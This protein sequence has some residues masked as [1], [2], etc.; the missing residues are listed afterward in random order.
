MLGVGA[1]PPENLSALILEHVH[2]A[3]V[4]LGLRILACGKNKLFGRRTF[5]WT[6]SYVPVASGKQDTSRLF[7]TCKQTDEP[8]RLSRFGRAC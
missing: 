2:K 1:I 8:K 3:D 5:W 6:H 4:Q 7:K